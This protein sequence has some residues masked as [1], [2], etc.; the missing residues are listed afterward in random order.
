MLL[1]RRI[2]SV[3]LLAALSLALSGCLSGLAGAVVGIRALAESGGTG[4]APNL[5]PAVAFIG[6]P[7]FLVGPEGS[8][9][10]YRI[11]VRYR[12]TN[13]DRG[14]LAARVEVARVD[15]NGEPL[16]DPVPASALPGSDS[17]EEIPSGAGRAF[18]WDV[19]GTAGHAA[20]S[21]RVRVH[22][23]ASED[24]REAAAPERSEPFRAG[25]T[26]VEVRNL[27][28]SQNG[29]VLFVNFDLVDNPV[30]PRVAAAVVVG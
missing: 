23:T 12:L 11:R 22:I 10:P 1:A 25:N 24:G 21:S 7:K 2:V 15:E 29:E 28:L 5:P 18:D 19:R 6:Q 8:P 17:L 14:T 26:P 16:G 4:D 13:E 3:L 20:G 27:T 9:S 30:W